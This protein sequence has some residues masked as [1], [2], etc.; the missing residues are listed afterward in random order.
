MAQWPKHGA[1]V[2]PLRGTAI[3]TVSLP[4]DPSEQ[5]NHPQ[6]MYVQEMGQF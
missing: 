6:W 2:S 4:V 5:P 1:T 3:F